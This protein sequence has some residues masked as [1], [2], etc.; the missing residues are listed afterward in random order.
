VALLVIV[1]KLLGLLRKDAPEKTPA[2]E[3]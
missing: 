2:E 3:N 1:F